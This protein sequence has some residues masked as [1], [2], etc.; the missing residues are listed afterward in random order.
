MLEKGE[1]KVTEKNLFWK[2]MLLGALAGGALSLFDKQTR[3]AMKEGVQKTSDKLAF[4]V[5]NP[6]EISEKMKDTAAKLKVTVEQVSED[7][8]YISGKVEELRE[9]TPQVNDI[10]KETKEAFSMSEETYRSDKSKIVE[11][12]I[13]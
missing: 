8:S 11:E 4:I 2:G 6:K 13:Q 12:E 7:I 10:L 9:L 1:V 3:L 5:H